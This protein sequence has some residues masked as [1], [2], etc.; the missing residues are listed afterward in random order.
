MPTLIILIFIGAAAAVLGA[1]AQPMARRREDRRL[2]APGELYATGAGQRLHAIVAGARG[3]SVVLDAALGATSLSWARVQP[4]LAR[5]ARV[6]SYDRAG[7]GYSSPARSPRTLDAMAAELKALLERSE[8]P[9]PYILV[10]HSY[11]GLV[12]RRY[13]QQNPERVAGLVLVDA[14]APEQWARPSRVD[15]RR[16][17]IGARLARRGA[18]AARIGLSRAVA[19]MVEHGVRP[20][21]RASAGAVSGGVLHG[22]ATPQHSHGDLLLAPAL[23]LPPELRPY[24]RRNWVRPAYYSA[25]AGMMQHLPEGAAAMLED[26]GYGERPLALLTAAD[27][28]PERAA[29]QQACARLSRRCRQWRARASGHWIP[30]DEPELVVEAVRWVVEESQGGEA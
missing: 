16:L 27:A 30:I 24:L 3:P 15:R 28:D 10:G 2:P 19:W 13:A 22:R 17:R 20:L 8:L 21:A 1:L 12:A 25:L 26:A 4:E 6:L 18:W 29:E 14:A 23:R 7:F 9:A 5:F 11:G